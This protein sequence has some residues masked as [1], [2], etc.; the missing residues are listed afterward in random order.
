MSNF[1]GEEENLP[2]TE[3]GVLM[4]GSTSFTSGMV[5]GGSSQMTE[6]RDEDIEDFAG[7]G[8]SA[9]EIEPDSPFAHFLPKG[10][11][12]TAMLM[13]IDRNMVVWVIPKS[14]QRDVNLIKEELEKCVDGVLDIIPGVV[15][16]VV[17]KKGKKS[18]GRVLEVVDR[19][20]VEIVDIDSGEVF[21]TCRQHL[22][23]ASPFILSKPPLAIPLILYGVRRNTPFLSKEARSKVLSKMRKSS[24]C[25]VYE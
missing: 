8:E 18:R 17:R 15:V 25:M 23:Q 19:D 21:Q 7:S 10:Q 20:L 14:S 12:F 5:V 2:I 22:R 13:T 1:L 3:I 9:V 4:P 11:V 6:C 16:V 24:N